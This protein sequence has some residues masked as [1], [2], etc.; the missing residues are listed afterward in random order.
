MEGLQT[1]KPKTDILK[2][3][4]KKRVKVQNSTSV[5][6]P[7]RICKQI[8]TSSIKLFLRVFRLVYE[9][10]NNKRIRVRVSI[11]NTIS[12]IPARTRQ[13]KKDNFGYSNKIRTKKKQAIKINIDYAYFSKK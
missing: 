4:K 12:K 10:A 6:L 5:P 1:N 11:G 7:V 3:Y 9:S 2:I 8:S 13:R